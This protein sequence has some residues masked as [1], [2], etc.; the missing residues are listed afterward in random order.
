MQILHSKTDLSI[1]SFFYF[2]LYSIVF[3]ATASLLV[4]L[5]IEGNFEMDEDFKHQETSNT[6]GILIHELFLVF[7]FLALGL[8]LLQL[9]SY[10]FY[11]RL[12]LRDGPC[13]CGAKTEE[14]RPLPEAADSQDESQNQSAKRR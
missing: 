4:L 3:L 5:G 13:L 14:E 8:A 7:R 2:L 10:F 9:I 12:V 11:C 1:F 6:E